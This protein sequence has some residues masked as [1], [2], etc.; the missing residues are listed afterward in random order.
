[1][2]TII[3]DE[4]I[5]IRDSDNVIV[6]PAESADDPNFITYNTWAQIPG[7]MPIILETRSVSP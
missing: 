3:L 7:N 4:G 5:V 6:S 1:M 2:Y